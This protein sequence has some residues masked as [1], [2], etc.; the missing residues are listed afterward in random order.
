MLHREIF[1]ADANDATIAAYFLL[2][3]EAGL[4]AFDCAKEWAFGAIESRDNP[5]IQIIE[6]AAS[7]LREESM[8][9]LAAVLGD[10]DSALAGRWLIGRIRGDL[11]AGRVS[12]RTAARMAMQVAG[13]AGLPQDLYYD[14]D[15]IDDELHLAESGTYSTVAQVTSDL[16]A[17][18]ESHGVVL[19]SAT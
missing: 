1:P 15:A 18:L 4:F 6:I 7:N 5:P 12:T 16:L 3:I 17:S 10:A 14:F 8:S 13:S 2:G 19:P 9:N 11:V